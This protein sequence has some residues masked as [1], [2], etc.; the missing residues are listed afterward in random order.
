ML[1]SNI[2]NRNAPPGINSRSMTA[3]QSAA[4]LEVLRE[5]E[6]VYF[7]PPAEFDA[8][9]YALEHAPS[10]PNC[11]A[12]ERMFTKLKRQQQ[13]VSGKALHLISQQRD[14]CDREFAEIQNIRSQLA[15]TLQTCRRARERLHAASNHLTIST[16]VIL[17]NVRKRQIIKSVLKSLDL[18][19]SLRSVEKDAADLLN[20]KEYYEAIELILKS[21]RA[22]AVH[23]EYTCI[24]DL[25]ARLQDTLDMTE[26][27]LDSVLAGVCY[28]FDERVFQKLKKAYDLLGKTQA[29]MEQLHMH[30]CSAVNESAV[31]AV[32]PFVDDASEM[33]FAEMCR[34]VHASKAPTCLLSLCEKLFLVMRS[35]YL[36]VDWHSKNDDRPPSSSDVLEIERNVSREYIRQKLKAGL[37]RIWHDVQAKVSMFLKSSGLEE[38]PF[39]KFIQM[40]GILRKLTQIAEVFCGDTSDLLHDFIKTQSVSYIKNYHRGRMEELKLFLENEG[41]EQCPVRSDFNV[42]SLQEFKQFRKYLNPATSDS[43]IAGPRG[44]QSDATS[45]VP[46][47][48]DSEYMLRYFAPNSTRTPFDIFRNENITNDDIFGLEPESDASDYSDDEPDELRRDFV[49]EADHGDYS[50]VADRPPASP[51]RVRDSVIVTNTTLSVLRNCGQ[52]LQIGRYLPQISLEVIMLMNQLFDY[53]F[54]TVHSFFTSDLPVSSSTLYSTKLN[55]TLKRITTS[56]GSADRASS[57]EFP[58]VPQH[59]DLVSE[60]NLHGLS[61]RI[62]AV[63]SV[64]FLAKQFELLHPYLEHVVDQPQ[65]MILDHF[66]ESTLAAAT[67]L[68]APVYMCSASRA[69]EASSTLVAMAQVRWNVKEVAVE[70]SP[71]VDTVVRKIQVFALRLENVAARVSL[72]VQVI[73]S[74]WSMVAKFIVHLLVEGFSNATK[75][76]NGGRSLMQLDYRQLF[77]KLE[78]I[79]R[80]KP[81][82]YQDYVDRYVKAYYLPR[83]ELEEFVKT[84][85]EYSNKHLKALVTCA[86]ENKR[87]R[88][89]LIAI[90]EN[91]EVS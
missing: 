51:S 19:R 89:A 81:V 65:R 71:Y 22:A 68:R 17:A 55:A 57:V 52:Y 82:P 25:A 39:E 2:E 27:K 90:I 10:P 69:V 67:D 61:E 13:V 42:L 79:S 86:C 30:Y 14:N 85:T 1:P 43:A 64:V 35:Y 46:S 47:Q 34:A 80:L 84:H 8:A 88:Q 15:D 7:S 49:D 50:D 4:D 20:K 62:V 6:H 31:E 36:L 41:W 28:E 5:I 29:A 63:E 54:Y 74:V 11:E 75:C 12:I 60:E 21:R 9:R 32:R 66:K 56:I 38:Y 24:A 45:S 44:T 77:V 37:I 76:S 33:K 58:N 40:L 59:L 26:E 48:D 78:K 53:Y 87:D 72:N 70:H 91:K 23:K 3:A 73:N 16:F 83:N 18:L